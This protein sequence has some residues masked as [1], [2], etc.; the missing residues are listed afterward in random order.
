MRRVIVVA[1][2][3]WVA[4]FATGCGKKGRAA[5][6]PPPPPAAAAAL[7]TIE[8]EERHVFLAVEPMCGVHCG[9]ERWR[10]KTLAGSGGQGVNFTAQLTTIKK[11][12]SVVPPATLS[13]SARETAIEKQVS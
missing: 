12:V 4:A 11:L 5:A 8:E 13:D 10:V 7:P 9:T 6:P 1:L 3:V 2:S